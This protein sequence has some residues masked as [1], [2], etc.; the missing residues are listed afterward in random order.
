MRHEILLSLL[1]IK[2]GN[3][4][5]NPYLPPNAEL[6]K[7]RKVDIAQLRKIAKWV[8]LLIIATLV[9]TWLILW[10]PSIS[11]MEQIRIPLMVGTVF[12]T[13]WSVVALCEA[14]LMNKLE[15]WVYFIIMFVPILNIIGL[16][17]LIVKA[18]VFVR[19]KGYRLSLIGIK[20]V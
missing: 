14:L 15:R 3:M 2:R 18:I 5:K 9:S 16:L 20:S 4:I 12:F 1:F 8:K 17:I 7:N 19:S 13:L 10:S 11:M 6:E